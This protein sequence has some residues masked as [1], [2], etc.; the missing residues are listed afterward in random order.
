MAQKELPQGELEAKLGELEKKLSRLHKSYEQYFIG[1]DKMPPRTQRQ[2][3]VRLV[4]SMEQF[5]IRSTA[6][7]FRLRAL[8]QRFNSYKTYWNRV[9]RE[10][11][12][13]TYKRHRLKADRNDA[14]RKRR[15][16]HQAQPESEDLYEITDAEVVALEDGEDELQLLQVELEALDEAGAFDNYN[17]PKNSP[18]KTAT[19]LDREPLSIRGSK[20]STSCRCF[21][22]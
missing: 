7:K 21:C 19:S 6:H 4:H 5:H 17:T 12:T 14:R 22:R 3:V 9:E 2:D 8:V 1:L 15:E 20:S 16:R 11:E 18:Q 13:G 10:I